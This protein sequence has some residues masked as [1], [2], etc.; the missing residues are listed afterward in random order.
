MTDVVTLAGVGKKY[1]Q[2]QER[3]LLVKSVIPHRR[4][5]RREHWALR[6]V[7]LT[8]TRGETVGIIGRNGSGKTT[9]LRLLAGVSRP[10]EGHVRIV[11]RTAPLIGVGIGFHQE[12]SGRENVYVNGMLL[13]LTRTELTR[14]FDAIAEF[15]ELDEAMDMPVKFYS[16]GMF[17]RLGFAVAVHVDPEVMLVDEVLAVGDIA[18]QLKCFERMRQLQAGGTT[19]LFVSHSMHAVRLLCPRAVLI[20]DGRVELDGT[21]EAAI[22][23]HHQIMSAPSHD[24][25][26]DGAAVSVTGQALTGPDGL[27]H[28]PAPG[29]PVV[30]RA[31]L[32]FH[33]AVA[34]PQVVFQVVSE[35][36]LLCYSMH[37]TIGESWRIFQAGETTDVEIPFLARLG[38][39]SFRLTILV[40]DAA[41]RIV[42]GTDPTGVLVYVAPRLG[43]GGILD[44]DAEIRIA[45]S[46]R[47]QHRPLLV[48][49]RRPHV[50]GVV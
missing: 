50:D 15:A 22:A 35:E 47:S 46:S 26:A 42:L 29:D 6:D 5:P 43:S 41:G 11:G 2:V 45:G 16:S 23:R 31:Q 33:Q 17:M 30:Y 3:R 49:D 10:S 27:T 4:R 25:S 13:G 14:R 21:A 7:N 18:F 24:G 19:I 9:L 40:T 28:H 12:M 48:G 39:G 36:G 32:R 37:T 34:S 20:R 1:N 44:L 38:G 8:V